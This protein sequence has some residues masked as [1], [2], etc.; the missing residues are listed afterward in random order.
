MRRIEGV[1]VHPVDHRGIDASTAGGGEDHLLRA[2]LEVLSRLLLAREQ[3]G[4]LVHDVDTELTPRQLRRV[5]FGEHLDPVAV[6]H[7]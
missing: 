5:P 2:A 4:A 7:D 6:D 1:V 3:S